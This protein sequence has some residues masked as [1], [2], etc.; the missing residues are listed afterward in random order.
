MCSK[1]SSPNT[2]PQDAE[3]ARQRAA[4]QARA[5]ERL[6]IEQ[7][8]ANTQR[9]D[10]ERRYQEQLAAGQAEAER[11]RQ[12]LTG[13]IERRAELERGAAAQQ[14]AERDAERAQTAERARQ[15]REFATQRQTKMDE[16]KA[17]VDSAYAGFDDTY[18]QKFA[19]DFT[20]HYAPQI[21]REY[22]DQR[23]QTTNSF[24]DAGTLR[25][26]MSADA[27][28]DL[29]RGRGEKE[30]QVASAAQDRAQAFE[31]DILGQKNDALTAINSAGSAASPLLPDGSFDVASSL[32]GLNSQ[33]GQITTTAQNR[34]QRV[35]TP[36]LT[37]NPL[38]LSL[39]AYAKRPGSRPS[40]YAV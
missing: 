39:A 27:F 40:S 38:D 13:E 3:A 29:T 37:V 30:A 8:M 21:Q 9:A 25:S 26:S 16:A 15:A 23:G 1:T 34:A 11:Q 5:E 6:R 4:E 33:L 17:G 35:N 14:Q 36:N 22:A 20:S 12:I 7:E 2:S 24:A 18:F 28:G 32:G 31:D 19:Q 10:Q